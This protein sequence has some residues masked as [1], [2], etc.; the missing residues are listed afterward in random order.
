MSSPRPREVLLAKAVGYYAEHGVRDTSLRTLAASIGTRP[1][2][3]TRR[4]DD[5]VLDH[6]R[7][8]QAEDLGAEVLAAI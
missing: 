5:G 6:L 3:G 1:A 2:L 8:D 4:H 7:L